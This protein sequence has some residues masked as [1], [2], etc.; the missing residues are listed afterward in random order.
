MVQLLEG[1][2]PWLLSYPLTFVG[3]LLPNLYST[4]MADD[5]S[6]SWFFWVGGGGFMMS[7]FS[8]HWKP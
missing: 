3:T 7:F 2:F 5:W 8:Y 6:G 4:G 1:C